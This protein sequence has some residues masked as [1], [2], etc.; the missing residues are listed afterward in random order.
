MFSLKKC[1]GEK[2][3]QDKLDLLPK[4]KYRVFNNVVLYKSD[5][6]TTEIDSIV[7]SLY[8]IF[9]IE[10]KDIQGVVKGSLKSKYWRVLKLSSRMYNK[11]SCLF[12]P[13]IQIT[14]I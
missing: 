5:G 12:S 1:S 3:V 11:S 9:V 4:D 13:L 8:G 10:T 14:Y 6:H 2:L 7:V